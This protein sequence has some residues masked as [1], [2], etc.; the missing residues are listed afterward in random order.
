MKKALFLAQILMLAPLAYAGS[1]SINPTKAVVDLF[2]VFGPAKIKENLVEVRG[3]RHVGQDELEDEGHW[4]KINPAV[5]QRALKLSQSVFITESGE[6]SDIFGTSFFIGNNLILTNQHVLSPSRENSTKCKS[7]KVKTNEK[8]AE[9]FECKEVL[10]CESKRDFCLI[11]LKTNIKKKKINGKKVKIASSISRLGSLKLDV[12]YQLGEDNLYSAEN[13]TVIG[14]TKG[15][16][17]HYSEG[18]TAHKRANAD[19]LFFSPL[20]QGNSGGPLLNQDGNVIGIVKQQSAVFYGTG[21]DVY[22][23]A[24]PITEV[25]ETL[26]QKLQNRPEVLAKLNEALL[27]PQK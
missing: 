14:N 21:S 16:G 19:I 20:A 23:V 18:R 27:A 13:F 22:N 2:K 1:N 4:F 25:V 12:N 5:Y 26:K 11:E 10:F 15:Y 3:P 7:L 6:D 24:V 17:I 9:R 8:S